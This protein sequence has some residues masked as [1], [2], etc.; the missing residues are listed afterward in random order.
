[1][2]NPTIQDYST[3]LSGAIKTSFFYRAFTLITRSSFTF[4]ILLI[5]FLSTSFWFDWNAEQL[6]FLAVI[7]ALGI[8]HCLLVIAE[9]EFLTRYFRF[10]RKGK[11]LVVYRRW[12]AVEEN[13]IVFG[14]YR[15]VWTA[16][17]GARLSHFGNLVFTSRALCGPPIMTVKGDNNPAS[18]I[19]KVPFAAIDL[20]TQ[21]SFITLLKTKCAQGALSPNLVAL[22]NKPNLSSSNYISL[23]TMLIFISI[24]FDVGYSTFR[25]VELLKRYYLSDKVALSGN[26]SEG[27]RLYE[28]AEQLRT[29][30]PFFSLVSKQLFTQ[31]KSLANVQEVRSRALWTLGEKEQALAAQEQA[32]KLL[33]KSFKVVLCEVRMYLALGKI[34]AAKKALDSLMETH[35]HALLPRLYLASILWKNNKAAEARF[36]LSNYLDYLDKDYFSPPPVWPSGGEEVLHELFYQDDLKFLFSDTS[37]TG[38]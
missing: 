27:Q 9:S 30:K 2:S 4:A 20:P 35:K 14:S 19:L 34:E 29:H 32:V 18:K 31:G 7:V 36:Y 15:L 21:K 10:W 38:K 11:P 16:I 12:L 26:I 28:Q 17:D 1:M 13:A 24:L 3:L 33:P 37:S 5:L 6:G 23:F 25:Y 22:T 8:T